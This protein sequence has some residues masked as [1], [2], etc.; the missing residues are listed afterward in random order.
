MIKDIKIII[1]SLKGIAEEIGHNGFT[2]YS[3]REYLEKLR[4]LAEILEDQI[5]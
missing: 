5:K 3:Q 4:E 1:I 2:N